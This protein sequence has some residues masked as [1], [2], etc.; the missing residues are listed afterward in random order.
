VKIEKIIYIPRADG[1]TIT[2]GDT[3]ELCY[4]D[5]NRW[6]PL[7]RK[8]AADITVS[9]DNCPVGALFLLHDL[10]RGREERIF[11]VENGEVRWW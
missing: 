3:Y 8:T 7:G 10:T 9:F 2:L 11:T 5:N 1:N 6:T 4:W